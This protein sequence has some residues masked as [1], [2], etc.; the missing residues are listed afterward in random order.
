M[1]TGLAATDQMDWWGY[2]LA[3]GGN[4]GEYS[5]IG[6][7]LARAPGLGPVIGRCV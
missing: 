6:T 7:A 4:E 2:W 3:P 5:A 1:F